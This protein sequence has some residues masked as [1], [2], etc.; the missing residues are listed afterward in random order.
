ML[1][2]INFISNYVFE[3]LGKTRKAIAL[4]KIDRRSP[5]N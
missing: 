4:D 1:G 3:K 2:N 5:L